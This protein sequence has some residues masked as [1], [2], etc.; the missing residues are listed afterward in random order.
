MC[1]YKL[2]VNMSTQRLRKVTET[3]FSRIVWK[4][5]PHQETKPYTVAKCRKCYETAATVTTL[6]KSA[7][8][9]GC[10][11]ILVI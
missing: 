7:T 4:L 6:T 10:M 2:F 1:P 3:R 11:G 9:N 8:K 5:L